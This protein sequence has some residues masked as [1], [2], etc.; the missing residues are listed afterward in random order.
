MLPGIL[1]N[2]KFLQAGAIQEE[3]LYYNWCETGAW[4]G[5]Q[6]CKNHHYNPLNFANSMI[7]C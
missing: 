5:H 6:S 7:S 1:G 2:I 3:F 4:L